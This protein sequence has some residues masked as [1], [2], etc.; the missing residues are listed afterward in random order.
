MNQVALAAPAPTEIFSFEG[1]HVRTSIIHGDPWF[2]AADVCKVLS[3]QNSRDAISRL[4]EDERGVATT[5]TPSGPQEMGVI[6]ESGLY[7]LTLTSRKP[8]AK[9]FKKWVTSVLLP[10]IRK[11]EFVHVSEIP[12]SEGVMVQVMAMRRDLEEMKALMVRGVVPALVQPAVE[13]APE[14]AQEPGVLTSKDLR[15]LGLMSSAQEFTGRLVDRWQELESAMRHPPLN[16]SDLSISETSDLMSALLEHESGQLERFIEDKVRL[17]INQSPPLEGV[18]QVVE[19]PNEILTASQLGFHVR[20]SAHRIN[21]ILVDLGLQVRNGP[22]CIPTRAAAGHY[23]VVK[24]FRNREGRQVSRIKWKRSVL[25]LI[26]ER[27][28]S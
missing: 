19:N 22:E 10:G 3:V 20:L 15:R 7:S 13:V 26:P 12:I 25:Q 4:D 11:K 1:N 28:L 5:D 23:E 14:P 6:N 21:R 8:E 2:V 17:I 9:R 18:N 27:Y 24:S 16:V